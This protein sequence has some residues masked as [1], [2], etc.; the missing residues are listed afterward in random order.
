[1]ESE[2]SEW[3]HNSTNKI[4]F[5]PIKLKKGCSRKFPIII[6]I[7][8]II[9]IEDQKCWISTISRLFLNRINSRFSGIATINPAAPAAGWTQTTSLDAAN[10]WTLKCSSCSFVVRIRWERGR[11]SGRWV[12]CGNAARIWKRSTCSWLHSSAC[13]SPTRLRLRRRRQCR[14]ADR[15]RVC[16]RLE[17]ESVRDNERD[18]RLPHRTPRQRSTCSIWKRRRLPIVNRHFWHTVFKQIHLI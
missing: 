3:F 7:K 10:K 14:W 11:L 4:N 12:R 6:K 18:C 5:F 8:L 1:M 17:P 16:W 9:I 15:V 13:S 2:T